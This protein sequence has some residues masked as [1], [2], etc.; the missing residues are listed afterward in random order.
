MICVA[1][2]DKNMNNCL[3]ALKNVEMA[4]IRLDLTCF[5]L[6][7]IEEI[8]SRHNKLIA[9]HRPDK[10]SEEERM[11]NLKTA[12]KAGAKYLD[13]EYESNENY[14]KELI[15]FAHNNNCDVIISY[16]RVF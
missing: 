10:H 3:E 7:E 4:E 1:I 15:K 6:K 16:L 13:L 14:R 12:I 5:N 2:S 9:T 8:F 11:K